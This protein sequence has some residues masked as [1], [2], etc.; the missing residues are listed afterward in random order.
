MSLEFAVRWLSTQISAPAA[1]QGAVSVDNLLDDAVSP[2]AVDD[3]RAAQQET[4]LRLR[5]LASEL[6]Q[7]FADALNPVHPKAQSKVMFVMTIV[8]FLI[9]GIYRCFCCCCSHG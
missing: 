1:V 6:S 3:A 7:F 4:L 2:S 9:L 8:V 5:R